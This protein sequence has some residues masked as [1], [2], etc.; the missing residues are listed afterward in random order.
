MTKK[1]TVNLTDEQVKILEHELLDI[2]EWV[3]EAV[4][5]RLNYTLN[6]L[7]DEAR[8]VL[9]AD[10]DVTSIPANR[11]ALVATRMA[12]SDYRNRKKRVEDEDKERKAKKDAAEKAERDQEKRA[13]QERKD[14]EKASKEETEANEKRQ[15]ELIDA[16]VEKALN[17]GKKKKEVI[18]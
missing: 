13:E 1:I 14:R 5:G 10:P 2:D 11:E 12:R 7:A 16:A 9:I 6:V 8:E 18:E 4:N 17:S 3:Q 15:Q